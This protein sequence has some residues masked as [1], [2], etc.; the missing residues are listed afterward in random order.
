MNYAK[1]LLTVTDGVAVI[2]L[3]D[4]ATLNAAGIDTVSELADAFSRL[5][6]GPARAVVLTGSGRGFC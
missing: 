2:T 4:P 6:A 3:N 5:A 1:I